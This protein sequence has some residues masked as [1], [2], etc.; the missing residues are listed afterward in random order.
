[1]GGFGWFRSHEHQNLRGAEARWPFWVKSCTAP[2]RGACFWSKCARRRGGSPYSAWNVVF[3]HGSVA[4]GSGG[5][6]GRPAGRPGRKFYPT[7]LQSRFAAKTKKT[8]QHQKTENIK[9]HKKQKSLATI[10]QFEAKGR[11]KLRQLHFLRP[12][13]VA[14]GRGRANSRS[15]EGGGPELGEPILTIGS[16]VE[17]MQTHN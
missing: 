5:R 6:A 11:R 2:R 14:C 4:G 16:Y 17:A 13:E 10:P 15:E 12:E 8:T 9:K 7:K 3:S 1:M